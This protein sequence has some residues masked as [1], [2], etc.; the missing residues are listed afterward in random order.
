MS[1]T[2]ISAAFLLV[3]VIS[4]L[5]SSTNGHAQPGAAG[6]TAVETPEPE[7]SRYLPETKEQKMASCMA[8]WEADTHMTKAEW[9]NVCKRIE[10]GK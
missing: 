5:V 10:T 4:P 3:L 8:L 9:K 6:V 1:H 2:A 7:R